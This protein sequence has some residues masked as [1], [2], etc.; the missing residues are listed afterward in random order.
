MPRGLGKIQ[1]EILDSLDVAMSQPPEYRGAGQEPGW[2]FHGGLTVR[3]NQDVFDLRAVLHYMAQE[4][5]KL[6]GGR[7]DKYYQEVFS[8]A[9]RGLMRRGKLESLWLIPVS[10]WLP[11]DEDHLLHLTD[12]VYL[13]ASERQR[14]FVRQPDYQV[15][16]SASHDTLFNRQEITA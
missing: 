8:N 16:A 9:V 12:G 14:R 15:F 5:G 7:V 3:L 4:N 2:I 13:W 11:E 6:M 1:L 10:T